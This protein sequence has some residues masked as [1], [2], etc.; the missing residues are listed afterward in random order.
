MSAAH[1]TVAVANPLAAVHGFGVQ[2]LDTLEGLIDRHSRPRI[3]E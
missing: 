1:L 3:V 2:L